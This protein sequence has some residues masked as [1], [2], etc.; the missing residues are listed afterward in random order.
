MSLLFDACDSFMRKLGRGVRRHGLIGL[1]Q[2]ALQKVVR[3][4]SLLRPLARSELKERAQRALEFDVRFGVDTGGLIHPTELGIDSPNQLHAV[5][6]RGS[7]PEYFRKAI[8]ALPIKHERFVF[9]DFGSGKGRALLLAA[10]F[11]FRSIV[12][13]EFSQP[14]HRVAQENLRQFSRRGFRSEH[15]ELVCGD[16]IDYLLPQDR[17]VRYSCNPFGPAVMAPVLAGIGS[18]HAAHPR[19]IYVVYYNP[20]EAQLL[21]RDVCFRAVVTVGP[22]RIWQV[23]MPQPAAF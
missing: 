22:V 9:I 14:L 10:E 8:H 23:V 3:Q 5:S 20:K 21:D 17:L 6:Y 12:G 11:P 2:V 16:A 18:S 4:L 15:I 7:D 13:V 19:E 1:L